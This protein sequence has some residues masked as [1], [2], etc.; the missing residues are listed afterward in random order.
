MKTII[1]ISFSD[2]LSDSRVNRS[3]RFLCENYRVVSA[4]W[5]D[6]GVEN[7]S[8][9]PLLQTT[10]TELITSS[11]KLLLR[12]Y[13]RFYWSQ[14]P[15]RDA[16]I[17]LSGKEIDL[18]LANDIETLPL[19]LSIAREAKVILDAHEY[20]PRQGENMLTWRVLFQKYKAYLCQTYIPRV[21]GMITVSQG[22]ADRYQQ[23]T[24]IRPLVITNAPDFENLQPRLFRPPG[25]TIRLVHH[26]RISPSRKTEKMIEMMDYLDRRFELDLIL[27]ENWPGYL[28]HLKRFASGKPNVH[29]LPPVP[30]ADLSRLL[31]QYDIGVYLLEPVNFNYLHS[32]PNKFFEFIQARLAVA[33]GPSPEMARLVRKHDLGVVAADFSPRAL[34][35]CLL[36]LDVKKI[37]YFKSQ[38]HKVAHLLSAEQNKKILLDLVERVLAR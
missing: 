17:K 32:L 15:I 21:N 23:D 28:K 12:Q 22:I 13:E 34:A 30:M 36:G 24:G 18:V 9:I 38:S 19:A 25:D 6:P 10:R 16:Q 8:F 4:G 20:A 5:K 14:K 29:F 35:Q 7:V 2:L 27:M 3:I 11:P 33:I 31:N 1:I 37:E 26:G